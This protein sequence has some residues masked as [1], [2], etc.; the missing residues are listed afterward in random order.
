MTSNLSILLASSC[1]SLA[2]F[3]LPK[4]KKA[5]LR[6]N[7]RD[8]KKLQAVTIVK[9]KLSFKE[10]GVKTTLWLSFRKSVLCS[11]CAL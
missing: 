3:L 2:A 4:I 10:G 5:P 7:L 11:A 1:F 9:K 8:L 6:F